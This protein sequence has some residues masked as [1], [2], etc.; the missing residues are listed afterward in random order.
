MAELDLNVNVK[1]KGANRLNGLAGTLGGIGKTAA[2]GTAALAGAGAAAGV[3]FTGMASEAAEAQAKL[4]NAFK[5]M[6]AASFTTVEQLDKQAEALAKATTFDDEGIKELQ[7][8]MLTFGNVT[9]KSFDKAIGISA[10][11]AAFFEKDLQSSA[12]VVGK[13]LNDP[14]KG[15]VSLG[16]IGVQ[17]TDEQKK[18]IASLVETGDVAGAQAIILGEL[19]R[20]VGGTAAA[21]AETPGGQWQQALEDL[22]EAGEAIGMILLP[23]IPHISQLLQG[24][25]AWVVANLPTI[26]SVFE[27]VFGA[28]GAAFQF[29]T[30]NILPTLVTVFQGIVEFFTTNMPSIQS[31]VGGVFSTISGIVD[32][33]VKNILPGLLNAVSTI[34]NFWVTN[35]PTISSVFSQVFG[36]VA[37]V[38]KT[39]WPI[40]ES[41][42][43]VLFPIVSGAASVLF[44]A[45][46][47]AFKGIG[48]AVEV[49]GNVFETVFGVIEDVFTGVLGFV[50][51]LWN[52]FVGVWNG[53]E[54]SVPS[55]DIPFVGTVGGFALGLPDLPYLAKGG[56]VTRPTL[57]VIGEKGPEAVIPLR[58]SETPGT[59]NNFEFHIQ[60]PIPDEKGI[61]GLVDRSQRLKAML[62]A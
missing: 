27:T 21:L 39:V 18:T 29:F 17:F 34:I 12:V 1:T 47:V 28:I 35:W 24:F 46:D 4:E 43:T 55:V 15:L 8:T 50:K 36:A 37:N 19:E 62:P 59:V 53:I 6:D 22:G 52:A 2:I 31:S 32:Y 20:Q 26:K 25:A 10:D 16:R 40:I 14:I 13:A 7:A 30:D 61:V 33:F 60:S 5:G 51:G 42:A 57:A 54:I 41:I 58:G 44:S 9:D 48:G 11:L 45:L 56:I 49:M 38:V 23:L 3:V